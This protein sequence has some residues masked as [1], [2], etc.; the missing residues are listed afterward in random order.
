MH[1]AH[2]VFKLS[3]VGSFILL[4]GCS[5]LPQLLTLKSYGDNQA[6]QKKYAE[7]QDKSFEKL[8]KA[9]N[10]NRLQEYPDKK[11][12]LKYFGDPIYT[13]NLVKQGQPVEEWLY[14]YAARFFNSEKVY[15]YFD[16]DGKLVDSKHVLHK[17][18]IKAQEKKSDGASL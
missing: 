5:S 8:V 6:A 3:L 2:N 1:P 15:L 12:F 14:R 16:P 13:K 4:C 9:V 10:D 17:E 11:N 7:T 18:E